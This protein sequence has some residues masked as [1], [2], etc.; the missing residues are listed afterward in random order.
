MKYRL[1]KETSKKPKCK[2]KVAFIEHLIWAMFS[3]FLSDLIITKAL[4]SIFPFLREAIKGTENLRQQPKHL[5]KKILILE[6]P[7]FPFL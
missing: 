3:H 6:H 7:V 1:I 2:R 5:K 4:L